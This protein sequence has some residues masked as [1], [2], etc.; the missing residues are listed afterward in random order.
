MQQSSGSLR[1]LL[2]PS[3][4]WRYAS[5]IRRLA[6][7]APSPAPELV[8]APNA[9][10][11]LREYQ[12][13]CVQSILS[14]I[15]KGHKR[16]GISLAT[17]SG[18]T[19][20]FTQLIG[21]IA[22]PNP[23]ATQTLILVH[24]RELVEQAARH[25]ANA[26]PSKTIEI[27]MGN[28]HATGL[29]D[30]T[31]AS[32][33]SIISGDRMEKYDP[34]RFKLVL[35]DE[36]HH[37]VAAS[38]MKTLRHFGLLKDSAIGSSAALVGVSATLSRFDGLR[39]SD[40]IDHIVYHK[41]YIDMIA[42]NWL[43]KVIF[44]T[45]RSKAD[46]SRVRKAPTGDFQTGDLS[47]AVNTADTNE[48]TVR[49]WMSRA[50]N[51]HSTLVFC[52]DLDHVS[53]LT[54]SFREIGVDAKFITGNTPKQVRSERLDAFRNGEFPVLLNCGV[55]TEG[56]DIPNIDCVLLARPTKSRNL[57]VQMVGRGMRLHPGKENCHIIDM[58]ASLEAGIVTTPTLFGL[59]PAEMVEEA[60]VEEMKSRQEQ[61]ELEAK[62]EER[63]A[64]TR[65][66]TLS[67]QQTSRTITFTDYGSVYDLIDDT[68]G[69][70]HIR[71]MSQLSWVMVKDNRYVLSNQSGDYITI[72]TSDLGA[73]YS[74][75]Y[76][77]KI[78]EKYL[79]PRVSSKGKSPFMRPRQIAKANTLSDAVH[80]ADTFA[81]KKFPWHFVHNGQAWRRAPATEGQLAFLNKFRPISEQLTAEMISK[82]KATDMISKVKFGAKGW[83]SKL[84]ADKKRDDRAVEQ[85]RQVEGLRRR[86]QVKVGPL[87]Q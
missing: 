51:R 73:A 49:A 81:L 80:A 46:V 54:A 17:G 42:E 57:L 82:G 7:I 48:I 2:K 76:V 40:A 24:R 36:A 30:I 50:A 69:E 70:R 43:S 31:I 11:R 4:K 41:D 87:S 62:R 56:T 52:V 23:D 63:V 55:F 72:E 67:T 12:E 1:A 28:T 66:P 27:E 35:V 71:G 39:L 25:C 68:S 8:S 21:R 19:V 37:I 74:V 61:K 16:L 20:I 18:K 5:N 29:A 6:T 75:I 60:N 65:S 38:F 53:D 26:Y 3:S 13:D 77:Q 9:P 32:I 84:E 83:F 85:V 64:E 47:K 78:P 33:W 14:Y 22:S 45:V 44:T 58:V 59:D 79:G 86:E 34:K 10:V 15:K